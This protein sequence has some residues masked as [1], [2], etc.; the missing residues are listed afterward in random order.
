M[1]LGPLEDDDYC[2]ASAWRD[3]RRARPTCRAAT[4]VG[5]S[6]PSPVLVSPTRL[7]APRRAPRN[8]CRFGELFGVQSCPPRPPHE[9]RH[10]SL[11]SPEQQGSTETHKHS[12]AQMSSYASGSNV[13]AHSHHSGL[14]GVAVFNTSVQFNGLGGG[15]GGRIIHVLLQ[16]SARTYLN[17]TIVF[18][19]TWK[20]MLLELVLA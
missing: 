20:V 12:Y 5:V 16:L 4:T 18:L 19:Q 8:R 6:D 2:D 1:L 13:L 15:G 7:E 11:T 10:P 3:G 17:L 9:L 14:P